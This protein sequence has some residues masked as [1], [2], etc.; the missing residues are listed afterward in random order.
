MKHVSFG[1]KTDGK[2]GREK[3]RENR[4]RKTERVRRSET[5]RERGLVTV[6]G[7]YFCERGET[8]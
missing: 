4:G 8:G 1:E 7:L 5:V 6:R 2:K 3:A